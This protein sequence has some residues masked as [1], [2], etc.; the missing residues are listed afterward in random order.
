MAENANQ[1]YVPKFY[2]KLFNGG[3][4]RINALLTK[5]GRIVRSAPIKGQC[6]RN[7]FYGSVEIEKEFSR[8]E[9]SHASAL[10][11]LVE[12]GTTGDTTKFSKEQIPSLLQAIAFQRARTMLELEKNAPAMESFL[13]HAFTEFLVSS[14]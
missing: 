9:G 14:S 11:A 2:F 13:L 10:R 4:P 1:H 6:A 7:M 5:D 3:E 8:L 12:V